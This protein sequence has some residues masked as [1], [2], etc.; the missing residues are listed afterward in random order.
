MAIYYEEPVS[1]TIYRL[2]VWDASFIFVLEVP[3]TSRF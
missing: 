1:N 2:R 3:N